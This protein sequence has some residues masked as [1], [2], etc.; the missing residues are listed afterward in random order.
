MWSKIKTW[1]A[2]LFNSF[3][4]I[5][6]AF[7]Q[8][9]FTLGEKIIVAQLKDFAIDVV[10]TLEN[11]D[12]TNTERRKQ[13]FKEIKKRAKEM[14]YEVSN[15][16]IYSIIELALRYVKNEVRKEELEKEEKKLYGLVFPSAV[17]NG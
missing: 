3:V 2:S 15:S 9:A 1:F 13:A 11:S 16:L 7:V 14:G 6:K 4:R 17:H 5:F 10:K 12:L 8:E